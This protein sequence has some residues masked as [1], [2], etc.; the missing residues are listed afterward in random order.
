MTPTD[1]SSPR[2]AP[3]RATHVRHRVVLV[4]TLMSLLLYLDRFCISF[5]EVFIKEDLG[6]SDQQIGWMFSAFFWTYALGQVPSGWLG[7]RFGGRAMLS[8]YILLWSLFTGLTG[9]AGAFWAIM[10]LRLGFGFAQAGAYPTGAGLVGRWAPLASRGVASALVAF[11]GRFGGAIAPVLTAYMIVLYVPPSVPSTLDS[12]DIL[13]G[14]KLAYEMLHGAYSSKPPQKTDRNSMARQVGERVLASMSPTARQTVRQAAERFANEEARRMGAAGEERGAGDSTTADG[15]EEAAEIERLPQ[16]LSEELNQQLEDQPLV[17]QDETPRLKLSNEATRLLSSDWRQLTS[18]QRARA[19]RLVLEAVYPGSI[20]KVY[21]AGWRPVMWTFGAV[22]I[23]VAAL[24]WWVVRDSPQQHPRANQAE[25]ELIAAGRPPA[26]ASRPTVGAI[27][28]GAIVAS[29]SMWLNSLMQFCTNV[30]WVFIVTWLPRYLDEVHQVPVERK[31]WMTFL[32]TAVG[33]AGMMLGGKL[34]DLMVRWAGP[35]WGRS[36]PMGL[37]RFLAVAA[38]LYCLT[39]PSPWM[40]V[41][42]FSLVAFSTDLGVP[43]VWSFQQDV[44]GRHVGSVFAWGNMWGNLGAA[45]TPPLMRYLVDQY[46]SWNAA[47]VL[48]AAAF[49]VAGLA[50]LGINATIPV[51]RDETPSSRA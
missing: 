1:I 3:A 4:A 7:D 35:R 6:L 44:G 27:P 49:L 45:A 16:V 9:A 15:G 39:E 26:T 33:M 47:F 48:C 24:F 19:N 20:R 50:G 51:A 46:Q 8:I 14:P 11:G 38:Y 13:D 29:R 2:A 37:T 32:P 18:E 30:G 23:L 12:G 40:A 41:A 31:G 28:L 34:T 10:A 21:G 42:A 17:S 22:G 25:R 43:A 5:A 36:V